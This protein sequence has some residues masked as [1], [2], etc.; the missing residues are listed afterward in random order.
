MSRN[1]CLIIFKRLG[2]Q[3]AIIAAHVHSILIVQLGLDNLIEQLGCLEWNI[4]PAELSLLL[5]LSLLMLT[6]G[7]NPHHAEVAHRSSAS[8]LPSMLSCGHTPIGPQ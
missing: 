8:L 2:A 7:C 6:R 3:S 4:V 5:M 1:A